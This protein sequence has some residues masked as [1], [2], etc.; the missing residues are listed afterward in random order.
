M[1][2]VSVEIINAVYLKVNA[3]SGIRME[4]EDYFKFQPSGYPI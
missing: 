3:D 4:L 1:D 2:T